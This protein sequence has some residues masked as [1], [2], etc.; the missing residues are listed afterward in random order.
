VKQ[1]GGWGYCPYSLPVRIIAF[2]YEKLPFHQSPP[3]SQLKIASI[4]L[5]LYFDDPQWSAWRSRSNVQP[6]IIMSSYCLFVYVVLLPYEAQGRMGVC[7]TQPTV[8]SSTSSSLSSTRKYHYI[9]LHQRRHWSLRRS[10]CSCCIRCCKYGSSIDRPCW[11]SRSNWANSASMHSNS[12]AIA[13]RAAL[14]V[15]SLLLGAIAEAAVNAI[16]SGGW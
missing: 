3:A 16:C 13:A 11:I 8:I 15:V 9:H 12:L 4:G 14:L 5:Q 10:A 7:S 1:M 2:E 6:P